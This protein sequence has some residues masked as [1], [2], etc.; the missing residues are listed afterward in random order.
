MTSSTGGLFL[1]GLPEVTLSLVQQISDKVGLPVAEV[2][3]ESIRLYALEILE[4]Q[5]R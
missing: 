3:S 2:I 4:Q 5:K 1:I